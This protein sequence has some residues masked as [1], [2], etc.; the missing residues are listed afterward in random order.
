MLLQAPNKKGAV[1]SS[2]AQ[3]RPIAIAVQHS[4]RGVHRLAHGHR[5][6]ARLGVQRVQQRRELGSVDLAAAVC[7]PADAGRA[8]ERGRWRA[9]QLKV[10]VGFLWPPA[11]R[12]PAQGC[13]GCQGRGQ[14]GP[15]EAAKDAKGASPARSASPARPSSGHP[16]L[17][18]SL[19]ATSRS[20]SG[21]DSRVWNSRNSSKLTSP[22][23]SRSNCWVNLVPCRAKSG[24]LGCR[25][26]RVR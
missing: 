7:S 2:T 9:V 22:L 14:N 11:Q 16:P 4:L 12:L 18:M 3:C 20:S 8:W 19:K 1:Q 15:R 25:H 13:N 26:V 23:P 24:Y 21:M 17:S 5:G 10:G 6:L